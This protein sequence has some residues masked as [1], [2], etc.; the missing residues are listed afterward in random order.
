MS[1]HDPEAAAAAAA[2]ENSPL[3]RSDYE[4]RK[5]LPDTLGQVPFDSWLMLGGVWIGVFLAA[6]DSTMVA[7]LQT[8]I[9]SEFKKNNLSSWLGTSYL[10]SVAAFQGLYGRISDIVGRKQASIF[11]V[12][13]FTFGTILCSFAPSME[14]IIVGRAI[15]GIGGGGLTTLSSIICSDLVSLRQRGTFQG[16]ANCLFGIC[17]HE[18]FDLRSTNELQEPEPHWEVL[19]VVSWHQ[20]TDSGLLFGPKSR[21]VL[22]RSVLFCGRSTSSSPLQRLVQERNLDKSISLAR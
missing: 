17:K 18:V 22:F 3:I 20:S 12:S 4:T 5:S 8:T 6:L 16:L 13:M 7:T 1:D 2:T 9:A 21:S 11:A 15:A 10:L 14:T 19:W